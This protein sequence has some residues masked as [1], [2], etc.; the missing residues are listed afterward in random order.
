[1]VIAQKTLEQRFDELQMECAAQGRTNKRLS[2][3]NQQLEAWLT[4]AL[5]T[6]P[7]PNKS[8]IVRQMARAGR[9]SEHYDLTETS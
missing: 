6:L 3:R 4:E 1:M 2:Q 8:R 5:R 9:Q 7:E